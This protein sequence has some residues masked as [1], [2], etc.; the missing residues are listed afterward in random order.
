MSRDLFHESGSRL[1][2]WS[3]WLTLHPP[4]RGSSRKQGVVAGTSIEDVLARPTDED[5]VARTAEE[6]VVVCAADE[7]VVAVAA[8]R[9]EPDRAGQ[10]ARGLNHVVA[11]QR[12]DDQQVV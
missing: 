9:L 5:V 4:D 2:G 7:D 8:V 1:G 12:L 10:E 3:G 11:C 6:G